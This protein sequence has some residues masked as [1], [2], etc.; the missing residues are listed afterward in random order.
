MTMRD[1]PKRG[2]ASFG[3]WSHCVRSCARHTRL[4]GQSVSHWEAS[5]ACS[6]LCVACVAA[7]RLDRRAGALQRRG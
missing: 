7:A 3:I 4:F 1:T 5:A 6:P 2:E